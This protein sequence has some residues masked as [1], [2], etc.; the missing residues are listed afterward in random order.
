VISLTQAAREHVEKLLRATPDGPI[1]RTSRNVPWSLPSIRNN[2]KRLMERPKVSEHLKEH[3][4]DPREIR[5]YNRRHTW[6][7]NYLDTTG[8]IFSFAK[9]MGIPV[10]MLQIRYYHIDMNKLIDRYLAFMNGKE[11]DG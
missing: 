2:W 6:G 5:V 11:D 10:K 3:G 1:F 9:M 8:N 7:C 4:F